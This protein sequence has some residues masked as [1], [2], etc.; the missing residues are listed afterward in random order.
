MLLMKI[1][2]SVVEIRNK[3]STGIRTELKLKQNFS[4]TERNENRTYSFF[5]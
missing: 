3:N 1:K 5:V 4:L 2:I